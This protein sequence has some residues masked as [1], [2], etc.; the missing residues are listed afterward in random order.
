MR[1]ALALFLISLSSVA[2]TG[3]AFA[4]QIESPITHGCHEKITVDARR[5]ADFPDTDAAPAPTEDQ[6]RLAEDLTF[7]L[8]AD[9]GDV[10]SMTLL[11]GV[12]SNDIKDFPVLDPASLVEIHD[13]PDDQPAHCIRRLEDNG[14]SGDASAL[15][16]CR[17]FIFGELEAGRL[18]GDPIDTTSTEVVPLYLSIRLQA[19]VALPR[20]AYRLGR[21]IHALE[22]GY[23]HT[24]RNPITGEVRHVTNWIDFST[25]EEYDVARD[26]VAHLATI[27]D[28][29]RNTEV[30]RYHVNF[31]RD[32][33]TDLLNALRDP[34][35]AGDERRA[36]VSAV[37][38]RA[39]AIEPGCTHANRYCAAPELDEVSTGC[40][41][42]PGA[43][44]GVVCVIGW[45]LLARRRRA[46]GL[47]TAA[48]LVL[49]ARAAA[50]D[51]PFVEA[52]RTSPPPPPSPV[53]AARHES[54]L[55]WHGDFR[56]GAALDHAALAFTGGVGVDHN[57][58]TLGLV[59]E[60]NPW[61]SLERSRA[62]EGALN[63]YFT[64]ARRWYDDERFTLYSRAEVGTSTVLF[65]LVGVDEYQTGLY[66]GGALLGVAIKKHHG[67]RMT[68]DPSH[69][70][71][72][73]PKLT[74]LPFYWRQ[75][76]IAIGLEFRFQ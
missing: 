65:D 55:V 25:N 45:V 16:A 71:M 20:F 27:D 56:F 17:D 14:A 2:L 67:L 9:D 39:F 46:V 10:W 66:L 8:P 63:I 18:F 72:P 4:F 26:G 6:R 69:F 75:Y 51:A 23:A 68:L 1:L 48:A 44:I 31:A 37:L 22:D 3:D 58:W 15:A 43:G 73:I 50:A 30:E 70:S 5:A 40:T 76:R 28:C 19:E 7:L 12:R 57:L 21:A 32:A 13:D 11:L 61:F 52:E 74:G 54:G 59:A 35:G 24:L 62:R 29:L 33:V 49:V 60:W 42:S 34:S 41:T 53:A 64:L 36:R 47:P 38:D